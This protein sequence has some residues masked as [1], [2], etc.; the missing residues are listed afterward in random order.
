MKKTT[1]AALLFGLFSIGNAS[2][3]PFSI[4]MVGDNDFAIFS[5]TSTSV[6]NLLYQNNVDWTSQ[7]SALSTLTFNLAAGD[8][9]FYVLGMGGGGFEENISGAVN[10]VNMIDPSV[11][12]SM[13]SDISSFLSGYPSVNP[14]PVE[15]G[16]YVALLA[17]V[18]TA[19]SDSSVTWGAPTIGSQT[20]T[21]ASGFGQGFIFD[22]FTAHL[23]AFEAEDVNVSVPEPSML[24]LM[25]LGLSGLALRTRRRKYPVL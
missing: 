20:V 15:T 9:V 16:T 23:F 7:I 4:S 19:F 3:S 22:S 2:A 8:D 6:N 13:S 10:G 11:S 1:L 21:V 18:Q 12:V 24:V 25:G 14:N 5:G 17:D